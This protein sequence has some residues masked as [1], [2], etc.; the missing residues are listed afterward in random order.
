MAFT[1]QKNFVAE[2]NGVTVA[3]MF[4]KI[5]WEKLSL[6]ERKKVI[7][8]IL[9]VENTQFLDEYFS[10]YFKVNINVNDYLSEETNVCHLLDVMASYLLCSTEVKVQE[11]KEDYEYKFYSD[12]LEFEKALKKESNLE[13]ITGEGEEGETVLHFLK[14]ADRNT[15]IVKN[16][17][18]EK[19]DLKRNDELSEVLG[20]YNDF[21]ERITDEIHNPDS[22]IDR[23]KLTRVKGS[24]KDDMN[25]AKKDILGTFG[26]H[27]NPKESTKYD[28]SLFDLSNKQHLLGKGFTAKSGRRMFAKGLLYMEPTEDLQDDFNLLLI[29]L[30]EIISKS[31]LTDFE[32]NVL[33]ALREN[34]KLVQI[35][36]E[37][38][39][40]V[41]KVQCSIQVICKKIAKTNKKMKE[42][43]L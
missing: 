38:N 21:S 9:N 42:E 25:V 5:D 36:E 33:K 14:S 1:T 15:K 4:K 13:S 34:K 29:E 22:K 39:V 6:D 31:N 24:L 18:F 40:T 28:V 7:G 30:N 26:D 16:V 43:K 27:F 23:F 41:K 35:S 20:A 32:K 2:I 37:L 10:E 17:E 3:Q 8:D 11:Q 19:K 12:P